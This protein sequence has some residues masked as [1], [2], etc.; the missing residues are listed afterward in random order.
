MKVSLK[1]SFFLKSCQF[2]QRKQGIWI[3]YACFSFWDCWHMKIHHRR[4]H[5]D[6]S[7]S[8]EKGAQKQ[9]Y[10]KDNFNTIHLSIILKS[11]IKCWI[12]T[13]NIWGEKRNTGFCP[14]LK[15]LPFS[16]TNW[17]LCHRRLPKKHAT[18]Y[19]LATVQNAPKR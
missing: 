12:V 9:G 7:F 15:V 14:S 11:R 17:R 3:K 6:E 1:S 8:G 13:L 18:F 10:L 2:S 19:W 16:C 4:I 5:V